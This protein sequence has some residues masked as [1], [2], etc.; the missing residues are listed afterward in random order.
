MEQRKAENFSPFSLVL[1]SSLWRISNKNYLL[2]PSVFK[3]RRPPGAGI[4][5]SLW[6]ASQNFSSVTALPSSWPALAHCQ[7]PGCLLHSLPGPLVTV[8]TS[9]VIYF[10]SSLCGRSYFPKMTTIVSL[11]LCLHDSL[12]LRITAEATKA[13]SLHYLVKIPR[14]ED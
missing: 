7:N 10:G 12:C 6:L 1:M 9:S 2:F 11:T 14:D 3:E 5:W 8:E 13:G 4:E